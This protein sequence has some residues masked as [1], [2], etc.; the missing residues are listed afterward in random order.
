M[1]NL[2]R[3]RLLRELANR[4]TLTATAEAFFMSPSAVSQQL[5][6]FERE[7]GVTL[8]EKEGR[9][10]KLTPLALRLIENSEEIFA[11]IER[12]EGELIDA[13]YGITGTI[14]MSAFPT[15][16]R[17]IMVPAIAHLKDRHPHLVIDLIDEEPEDSIPMLGS[18]DLDLVVY[19][20]WTVL[21]SF[22]I[23]GVKTYDLLEENVYLGIPRHHP[24]ANKVGPI[25][26]SD[27]KNENWIAGREST[28]MLSIISAATAHAGFTPK[29]NFHSMDFE[30]ILSA[31][32]AG[33]GIA[34]VPSLGF[35]NK[36]YDVTY[37][38]IADLDLHRTVRVAIRKGSEFNP[39]ITTVLATISSFANE[40]DK[41]LSIITN[42]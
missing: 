36:Q 27:L 28:S 21:P 38:T 30:V 15:G 39:L 33:L 18:G 35:I 14:K 42:E 12:A 2:H 32:E 23:A 9:G 40:V 8:L 31:V 20:E 16:A 29:V 37:K 34:L 19:Y 1:L 22:P 11:A 5:A 26:V 4:K 3:L 24:L 7:V 17:A 10:V 13:S 6:L 41:E 25:H